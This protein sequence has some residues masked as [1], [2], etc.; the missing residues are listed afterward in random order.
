VLRTLIKDIAAR[1]QYLSEH[2]SEV[3]RLTRIKVENLICVTR[4]KC[5]F[6]KEGLKKWLTASG[7]S[8]TQLPTSR[9]I[10]SGRLNSGEIRR[11]VTR[12]S[13]PMNRSGKTSAMFR[14]AQPNGLSLTWFPYAVNRSCETTGVDLMDRPPYAAGDIRKQVTL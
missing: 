12:F 6:L 7:R 10:V 3:S 1:K 4:K 13:H 11:T 2:N 8:E 5:F 14:A 9:S